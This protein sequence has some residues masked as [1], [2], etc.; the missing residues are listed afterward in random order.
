MDNIKSIFKW[1]NETINIWTTIASIAIGTYNLVYYL[2]HPCTINIIP[3]LAI[4]IGQILHHPFSIA[5]HLFLSH[6]KEL[7]SLTRRLDIS[8]IFIMNI[9]TIIG[10]GNAILGHKLSIIN[11]I[12]FAP[13]AINGIYIINKKELNRFRLVCTIFLSFLGYYIHVIHKAIASGSINSFESRSALI[14]V[15]G[16]FLS[17]FVYA[18]HIPE[19]FIP[20]LF[21]IIGNSHN[22]MHILVYGVYLYSYPYIH[23]LQC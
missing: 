12:I 8:M 19:R 9:C 18:T 22:I 21:D 10:I 1:H 16:N 15:I 23:Y 13:F 4:W 2:N 5:Y 6:S 17:G 3:F 14:L 20:G 7:C 11:T